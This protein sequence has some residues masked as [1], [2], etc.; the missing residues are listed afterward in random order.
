MIPAVVAAALLAAGT[1]GGLAGRGHG[2]PS[3]GYGGGGRQPCPKR[4]LVRASQIASVSEVLQ[5]AQNLLARQAIN[6]QGTIYRLT[7]RNAPIDYVARV[8]TSGTVFD[9]T[10]P[11]LLGLHRAAAAAC[12]A[13]TA[14]ASW[15]IHYNVPVSV[16]AGSGGF[17]FLVKTAHGWTFWGSW[18][19]ANR[20]RTWRTSRCF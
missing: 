10:I 4:V 5:A 3:G 9:Q 1:A 8:A 13:A 20:S 6:S 12:G 2:A 14:Q 17:P 19:G 18:C 15:A 11:G 16:I 7:P